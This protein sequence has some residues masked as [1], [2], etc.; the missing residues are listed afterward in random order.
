[1]LI[2]FFVRNFRSINDEVELSMIPGKVRKH[3]DHVVKD[4]RKNG[5]N[6][7]KTSVL[8]GANAAGKSNIIEAIRFA[9]HLITE[10]TRSNTSIRFQRFRLDE[11][12]RN[13]PS[14][15]EFEI[16]THDKAYA[17]G[18][19]ITSKIVHTE[20]L[21]ELSKTAE[22]KQLFNRTTK[23]DQSIVEIDS[24]ALSIGKE[25]SQFLQFIA[26]GTR[27]NQLFLTE[28]DDRNVSYYSDVMTWFQKVLVVLPPPS[29]TTN[30]MEM[31]L[32]GDGKL[33][34]NLV[35]SLKGFNI[36]ISGIRLEEIEDKEV[37][38]GLSKLT[39]LFD[40]IPSKIGETQQIVI[41]G[42]G[43]RFIIR[44]D[45]EGDIKTF[46]V[47]TT[48]TT[49]DGSDIRFEFDEES[50][51]TIRLI[52]LLSGFITSLQNERVFIVDELDRSLHPVLS[53][54]FLDFFLKATKGFPNQLIVTTHESSI[55]D[56]ELLRR[57]EIWFVEKNK[58][59]STELY[60]LE[61]FTPRHDKDI[62]RGYLQGRYGAIPIVR[63]I[64]DLGWK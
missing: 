46:R 63:K 9:Q 1:M 62:R 2:R 58:Q 55:L 42:I 52:D 15:F 34:E 35:R 11:K 10:G 36:D 49:S 61:E 25:D 32:E 5:F 54:N 16:K 41:G 40:K 6:L 50:D 43:G 51:G 47:V 59:G 44:R 7:L 30:A 4:S 22:A 21:Y 28:C 45:E 23:D 27:P 12:A 18:F 17:Y 57:D 26:K 56:L 19:E 53:Y 13:Q 31:H 39:E 29:V 24:K 37:Q 3:P 20:W 8:Y 60:S 64:S 33:I 14:R 38:S 48:H